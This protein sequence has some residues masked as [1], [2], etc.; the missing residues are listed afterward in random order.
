MFFSL[1]SLRSSLFSQIAVPGEKIREK[2]EERKEAVALLRKALNWEMECD[3]TIS[4]R[5][6][7]CTVCASIRTAFSAASRGT[8][9]PCLICGAFLFVTRGIA[10]AG[11]MLFYLVDRWT[12]R[13][14]FFLYR[15]RLDQ[16]AD[17]VC[18][19]F[20]SRIVAHN[21]MSMRRI[22]TGIRFFK[23]IH[24]RH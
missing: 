1:L 23:Q 18:A 11:V 21:V 8:R 9:A 15:S 6:Q 5:I 16:S 12:S 13:L 7:S 14:P 4:V 19:R 22:L 2:R 10:H 24:A 17:A 3:V 20:K